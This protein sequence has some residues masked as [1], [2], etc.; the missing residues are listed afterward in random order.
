MPEQLISLEAGLRFQPEQIGA[1]GTVELVIKYHGDLAAIAAGL[2]A[3]AEQLDQ[4]FAILTL[5][6]KNF[7]KL[8]QDV[9][10]EYFELPKTMTYLLQNELS[11]SFITSVQRP[12]NYGLR[13]KGVLV[14]IIDSGIDYLH[15]DFRNPDG[16]SRIL[17]L[18]DQTQTG[19]P[20]Q[21]FRKGNLF[22]KEALDQSLLS[23][24][25]YENALTLDMVGHGTAV[26][27]IAAGNGR[28]SEGREVGVAPEAQLLVVKLAAAA[29]TDFARS[30]DIMR[31]VKF[32]VDTA[33]AMEMP[34]VINISYG[35]NEGAHDGSSLLERYLDSMSERWKTVICVAAG[36]E[37]SAGHHFY[38]QVKQSETMR[39]EFTIGEGVRSLYLSFWKNF[40]DTMRVE[41]IAP[42]GRST[43]EI[44]AQQSVTSVV[45]DRTQVSV[46]YGQPN[47]YRSSQEIYF[48]LRSTEDMLTQG[49]WTLKVVGELVIDGEINIWM[50]MTDAVTRKTSFLSPN[51][52][53]TVTLPA[54]AE[55]VI[56][57]GGYHALLNTI[58]DFSGR[59]KPY[60]MFGQKP[61]L[62][63]PAVDVLTTKAGGG[64]DAFSGTSVAA[65]FV[66]GAAALMMEWGIVQGHDP[67]L[68]GQRVKAFLCR[69]ATRRR[70]G[71]YPD[72]EWGYGALNLCDTMDDLVQH[73]EWGGAF[74]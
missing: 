66:T 69:N 14:G 37:G 10:I 73:N 16:S 65:P 59:G 13:G 19:T 34:L 6:A 62:V 8:F 70:P 42:S 23:N 63:A 40:A 71:K 31:G 9:R 5:P 58:A 57:V 29:H 18:W 41:L 15:P 60:G 44:S 51:P 32:L 68:Y 56:T 64:Y 55:R 72:S 12:N 61:D 47:H 3:T 27:G 48:A 30:T 67:F 53:N 7:P 4:N 36:N 46:L 74:Q 45:L 1:D 35:T 43:G 2:D 38:G 39:I 24:V 17:Y 20:P 50:P 52:E 25:T 21:G 22:R 54:T 11:I 28:S 49:T 33:V 26:S